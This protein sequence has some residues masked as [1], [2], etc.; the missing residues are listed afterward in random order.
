MGEYTDQT[1]IIGVGNILMQDEG[2]GVH[3][4][5]ELRKMKLPKEVKLVDGGTCGLDLTGFME[6]AKKVIIVDALKGG[7]EP[8]AIYRLTLD[9]I[10]PSS[11]YVTS[12]HQIGLFEALNILEL[13]KKGRPK[14]V[15]IIGVTPKEIKWNLELSKE[16]KE[17]FPDII[18]VVL[19]EVESIGKFR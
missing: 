9:D 13:L 11:E 14:E 17:R 15:I 19:A 7:E 4:V 16:L 10:A 8:G 3:I 2:I 12:L 1:V 5:R 6:E 18:K